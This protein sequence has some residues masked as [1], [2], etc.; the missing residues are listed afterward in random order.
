MMSSWD[1]WW[2]AKNFSLLDL[3]ENNKNLIYLHLTKD[4]SLIER[5]SVYHEESVRLF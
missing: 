5:M 2:A 3:I 1:K 4:V